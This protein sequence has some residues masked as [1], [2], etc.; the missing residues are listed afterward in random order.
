MP[1]EA[2]ESWTTGRPLTRFAGS[3]HSHATGAKAHSIREFAGPIDYVHKPRLLQMR[4]CND[5]NLRVLAVGD[6]F[7]RVSQFLPQS[8]LGIRLHSQAGAA[9]L[10]SVEVVRD[11]LVLRIAAPIHQHRIRR[12]EICV[13][14]GLGGLVIVSLLE[15]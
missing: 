10:R 7:E 9:A 11:Q 3:N 8:V 4:W 15:F 14:A 13:D 12:V 6:P 2:T 1:T 5:Q